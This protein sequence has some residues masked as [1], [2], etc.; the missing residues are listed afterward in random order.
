VP[1]SRRRKRED[2]R[3]GE[4]RPGMVSGVCEFSKALVSFPVRNDKGTETGPGDGQ[5]TS[6]CGL[7]P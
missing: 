1:T 7:S 4:T 3:G 6:R 2:D 5:P